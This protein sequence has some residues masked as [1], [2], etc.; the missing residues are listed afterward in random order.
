[1]LLQ[2]KLITQT[3]ASA[4]GYDT[5]Q[6]LLNTDVGQLLRNSAH[7]LRRE[8]AFNYAL[9][10]ELFIQRPSSDPL[11]RVMIRGRIDALVPDGDGWI[12]I[13]YKTDRVSGAALQDR[14]AYYTGQMKLYRQALEDITNTKVTGIYL[15]F[16]TAKQ[17]VAL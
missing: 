5:I 11:D 14:A 9:P 4:A 6:W 13:D 7:G 8:Q 10:P 15:V 3:Q 16:L 1:M 12:I 17:V 2:R